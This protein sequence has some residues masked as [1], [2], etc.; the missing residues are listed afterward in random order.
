MH[1][2]PL[3]AAAYS[4]ARTATFCKNFHS[5]CPRFNQQPFSHMIPNRLFI[6]IVAFTAS[7]SISLFAQDG[8]TPPSWTSKEGRTIQGKFM[9]LDGEAVVIEKAGKEVTIPFAKLSAASVEQAKKAATSLLFPDPLEEPLKC[10]GLV[11]LPD[12]G[13]VF[14]GGIPGK[15]QPYQWRPDIRKWELLEHV[16]MYA[17]ELSVSPLNASQLCILGRGG[18]VSKDGG[19]TWTKAFPQMFTHEGAQIQIGRAFWS[20]KKPD[21]LLLAEIKWDSEDLGLF[22]LDVNTGKISPWSRIRGFIYKYERIGQK[23]FAYLGNAWAPD[24]TRCEVSEDDGKTWKPISPDQTS[25]ALYALAVAQNKQ[26]AALPEIRKGA[27]RG[28]VGVTWA[29]EIAGTSFCRIEE[30]VGRAFGPSQVTL[31]AS[32]DHGKTWSPA[33]LDKRTAEMRTLFAESPFIG[34]DPK[35]HPIIDPLV[36]FEVMFD[37]KTQRIFAGLKGEWFVTTPTDGKWHRINTLPQ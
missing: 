35:G 5:Y 3:L 16:G 33:A 13:I 12:G 18:Y 27:V 8:A 26:L 30:L 36:Q 25:W 9:K 34:K 31:F 29:I 21:T 7:A 28:T 19:L 15:E 37:A 24:T 1:N 17:H 23:H 32:T 22:E 4:R 11:I 14:T 20:I 10:D 2:Q 6:A